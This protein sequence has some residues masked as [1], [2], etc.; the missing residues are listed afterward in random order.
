MGMEKEEAMKAAERLVDEV[1]LEAEAEATK[2]KKEAAEERANN[3]AN[4]EEEGSGISAIIKRG[5]RLQTRAR[6]FVTRLL[7]QLRIC[8]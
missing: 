7:T 8:K 4:A 1:I 5:T 3:A 6:G 2:R